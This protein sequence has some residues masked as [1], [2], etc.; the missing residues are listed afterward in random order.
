MRHE[1]VQRGSD[2]L[3]KKCDPI[4]DFSEAERIVRDM[5]D[6][7]DHLK[8][9]YD[10]SRG[11]GIA[12][13]QIGV[14]KRIAIIEYGKGRFILINPEIVEA[15]EEKNPVWEGCLSFF[16]YRAYVPRHVSV[17]V[18][19]QDLEQNEIILKAKGDFAASM[20]HEIDHLHGIL[21]VDR[22][23]NGEKDLVVSDKA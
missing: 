22:L 16:K 7:T 12:A 11:I 5:I 18:R 8:S 10:F 9:T 17:K 6:T 1:I 4:T 3:K 13:P 19:A 21:Y 20:Q 14:T 15:S 23:P 2:I